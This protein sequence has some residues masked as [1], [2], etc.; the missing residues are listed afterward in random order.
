MA[1]NGR[2]KALETTLSQLRRRFGEGAIMKLGAKP[3]MD[4]EA[5]STGALSLDIALGIGGIP[6]GRVTEIYGPEAS[7]K[8]TLTQHIIAEAQKAGGIGGLH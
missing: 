8:T 1:T 3:G 5:I 6:K 2:E 4:V 7:G